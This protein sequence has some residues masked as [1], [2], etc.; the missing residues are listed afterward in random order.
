MSKVTGNFKKTI[1]RSNT[2]NY[3]IGL[4]KVKETSSDLDKFI[5]KTITITGYL[6]DLNEIDT[7]VLDG[8]ITNH[9]KYGEQFVVNSFERIMPKE[10]DSIVSVLSSDMF[11][12]IGK[13]TAEAIVEMFH[14]DTFNVILEN[15]NNLL[16]VKG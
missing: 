10:T 5:N 4:F 16:L 15:P 6:P 7:Y 1:F 11:K 3:L 13:K 12:G 9:S 8:N 2:N 14:E